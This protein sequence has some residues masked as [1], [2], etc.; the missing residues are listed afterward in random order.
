MANDQHVAMLKRGVGVWNVWRDEN[1]DLR[2]DLSGE[3]LSGEMLA[4][5]NLS[6]TNLTQANLDKAMLVGA[7]LSQAI[8]SEAN[9]NGAILRVA[10]LTLANLY[11]A[12]LVWA[13]LSLADLS[14]ANLRGASLRV[15]NLTGAKL[16]GTDLSEAAL[17][18]TVFGRTTLS[19]V[20]GLDQCRH[21]GPSVIDVQTLKNSGP[22]PIA[23]LRGVGLPDRLIDYLPSLLSEAIQHYSCFISYSATIAPSWS[24]CVEAAGPVSPTSNPRAEKGVSSSTLFRNTALS[25]G[26]RRYDE[27]AGRP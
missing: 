21:M 10:N 8:L 7:N 12:S 22:L 6:G 1:P 17:F 15:T 27:S 18:G 11:W 20:K 13:D 3:V 16:A 25:A 23:F 4:L 14:Q 9:L 5:A 24:I 19:E 2:P 26:A